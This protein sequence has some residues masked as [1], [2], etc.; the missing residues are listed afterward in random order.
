LS[1]P[2]ASRRVAAAKI[3]DYLL[4]DTHPLGRAKAAF[5]ARFG[6]DRATWQKLAE[7]LHDHPERNSVA[8]TISTAFGTK[9]LVRCRFATPDGRD[10]CILTVWMV[11]DG[12]QE[13]RLV[14]A[15]PTDEP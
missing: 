12:L 9:Y 3:L 1:A 10:P 7:S 14:T 11:E 6:F 2:L 4:D 5:F 8:A 15:Y 13:A